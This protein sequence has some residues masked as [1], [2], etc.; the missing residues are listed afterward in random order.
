MTSPVAEVF[1]FVSASSNLMGMPSNQCLVDDGGD[2]KEGEGKQEVLDTNGRDFVGDDLAKVVGGDEE[3]AW[4]EDKPDHA[5]DE[6]FAACL[7]TE[8]KQCEPDHEEDHRC[9][10]KRSHIETV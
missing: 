7:S 3:D 5:H 2:T 6:L 4:R 8:E 9:Q 1:H 10:K